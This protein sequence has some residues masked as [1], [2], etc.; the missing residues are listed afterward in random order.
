MYRSFSV[1]LGYIN[2]RGSKNGLY[3]SL[4]VFRRSKHFTN[5]MLD[6]ALC[7]FLSSNL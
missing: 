3:L 4:E 1:S 7:E 2:Y 5:V 6:I